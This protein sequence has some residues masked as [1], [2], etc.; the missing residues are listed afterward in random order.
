MH[1]IKRRAWDEEEG[2]GWGGG[3]WDAE[4]GME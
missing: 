1:G 2:M 3:A 4:E